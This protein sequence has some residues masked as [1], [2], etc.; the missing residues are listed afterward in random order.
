MLE[1]HRGVAG[2]FTKHVTTLSEEVNTP[3]TGTKSQ[4][5][6]RVLMGGNPFLQKTIGGGNELRGGTGTMEAPTL[7]KHKGVGRGTTGL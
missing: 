1:I 3:N 6:H 7:G 4:A 2:R 5:L